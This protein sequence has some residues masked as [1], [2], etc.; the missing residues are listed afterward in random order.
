[1]KDGIRNAGFVYRVL[2]LATYR[3]IP[4]CG[5]NLVQTK[6]N[7]SDFFGADKPLAEITRGNATDWRLFL[8][9]RGLG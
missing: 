8:V 2:H 4:T 1:M 6:R 3:R 5:A 9:S 7:L